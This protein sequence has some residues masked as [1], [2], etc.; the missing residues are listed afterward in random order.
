LKNFYSELGFEQNGEIY[1][2]DGIEHIPMIRT[3]Q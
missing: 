3:A 1:L 2:E